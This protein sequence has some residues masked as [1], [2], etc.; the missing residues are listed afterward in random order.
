MMRG[1]KGISAYSL[2]HAKIMDQ[3]KGVEQLALG[4]FFGMSSNPRFHQNQEA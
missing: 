2:T 1:R 4:K 3:R